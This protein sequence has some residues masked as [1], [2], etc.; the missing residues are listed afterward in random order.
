LTAR[1]FPPEYPFPTFGCIEIPFTTFPQGIT[2][3]DLDKAQ[4]AKQMGSLHSLKTSE[5][6]LYYT[7]TGFKNTIATALAGTEILG[8]AY[9]VYGFENIGQ[10]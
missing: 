5:G 1:V 2:Q 9:L 7:G 6:T 3:M 10:L 4:L 8:V